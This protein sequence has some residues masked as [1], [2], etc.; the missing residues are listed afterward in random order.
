MP[1]F[2]QWPFDQ[3]PNVAA[4]TT[5]QVLKEGYPVLSVVHYSDD[6]SWAFTCGTISETSDI[7]VI[8]MEEVLALAQPYLESLT[9]LPAG[10][11][12]E[13]K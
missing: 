13:L 12:S 4:I 1:D 2:Q 7:K 5:R 11:Q 6:D 10:W 3:A 9:C 8:S